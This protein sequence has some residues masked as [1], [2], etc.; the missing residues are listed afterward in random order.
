[1]GQ[2]QLH[3]NGNVEKWT[4]RSRICMS[5]MWEDRKRFLV[6]GS[7]TYADFVHKYQPAKG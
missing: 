1:M 7:F 4:G 3:K 2:K 5:M 6:L